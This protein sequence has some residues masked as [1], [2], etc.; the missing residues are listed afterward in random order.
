MVP[1]GDSKAFNIV[2]NVYDGCK[3]I[4]LDRFDHV[5]KKMGKHLL[6]LK[7]RT[8]KAKGV[9]YIVDEYSMQ[10]QTLLGWTDSAAD[11][12]SSRIKSYNIA[13]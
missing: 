3:A 10:G 11:K 6:N 7:A 1:D 13:H 4:K 8:K 12:Q 2:K 5:Q 9:A